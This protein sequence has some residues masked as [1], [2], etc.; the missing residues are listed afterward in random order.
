MKLAVAVVAKIAPLI[1]L[2]S[3]FSIYTGLLYNEYFSIPTTIF[4]K[5]HWEWNESEK[6]YEMSS[7]TPYPVGVD[8]IWHGT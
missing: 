5:S 8:P 6:Q 1:L 3:V 2:M 4:G 7:S